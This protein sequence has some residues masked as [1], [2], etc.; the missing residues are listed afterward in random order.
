MLSAERRRAVIRALDAQRDTTTV[1]QFTQGLTD[2]GVGPPEN[3]DRT[4]TAIELRHAHLPKLAE[5]SVIEYD[6][7]QETARRG[8]HFTEVRS[9]LRVIDREREDASA[10]TS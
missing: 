1:E 4:A 10:A 6:P 2:R 5:M 9:L 3:D 8:R 7:A